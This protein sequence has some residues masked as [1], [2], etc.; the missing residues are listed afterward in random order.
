[1]QLVDGQPL[2]RRVGLLRRARAEQQRRNAMLDQE[3]RVVR[4]QVHAQRAWESGRLDGAYGG[5]A[6]WV[7]RLRRTRWP[8]QPRCQLAAVRRVDQCEEDA[9]DLACGLLSGLARQ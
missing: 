1:M 3:R 5:E 2:I 9:L 4:C 8:D 6:E 7:V